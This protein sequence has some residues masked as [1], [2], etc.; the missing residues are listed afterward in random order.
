M[1]DGDFHCACS[2]SAYYNKEMMRKAARIVR[3]LNLL[4]G[5]ENDKL[6]AMLAA[7]GAVTEVDLGE[8]PDEF[9][10]PLLQTL[11]RDPVTLPT[12]GTVVDRSTIMQHLLNDKTDPFSRSPLEASQLEPADE[13]KAK[14]DAFIKDR[15][16]QHAKG[17]Q[18]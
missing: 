5:T 14:I 18:S 2:R 1:A 15:T 13:L 4:S 6:D 16:E 9:L 17:D 12:S 7:I 3:R 11:M 8:I 10:D